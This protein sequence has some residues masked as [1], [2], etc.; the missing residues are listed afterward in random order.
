MP[1]GSE[2][3]VRKKLLALACFL[4]PNGLS[5]FA[6]AGRQGA[7]YSPAAKTPVAGFD[8]RMASKCAVDSFQQLSKRRARRVVLFRGAAH[9]AVLQNA[10]GSGTACIC[11]GMEKIELGRLGRLASRALRIIVLG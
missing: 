9:G 3:F 5:S 7:R 4:A 8:S 2:V 11:K 6:P 1:F 10:L